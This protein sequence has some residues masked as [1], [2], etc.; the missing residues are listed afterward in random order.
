[1]GHFIF[2]LSASMSVFAR[3]AFGNNTV[4]KYAQTSFSRSLTNTTFREQRAASSFFKYP[5]RSYASNDTSSSIREQMSEFSGFNVPESI[6]K[7]VEKNPVKRE[8]PVI[9]K[10]YEGNLL[11]KI[12]QVMGAVVDVKF[13][14]GKGLPSILNALSVPTEKGELI[15][16]VAQHLGGGSVRTIAMG[17]T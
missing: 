12:T 10:K 16:E 15:L 11:G 9:D 8:V 6:Q 14:R 13:E 7:E 3:R 4:R 5:V 1:M 2:L 17:S